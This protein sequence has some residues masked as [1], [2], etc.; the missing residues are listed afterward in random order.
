VRRFE[1]REV[2]PFH[3]SVDLN[4]LLRSIFQNLPSPDAGVRPNLCSAAEPV[5]A[6]CDSHVLTRAV[7]LLLAFTSRQARSNETVSAGTRRSASGVELWLAA[8]NDSAVSTA[9]NGVSTFTA[10]ELTDQ[11]ETGGSIGNNLSVF[12]ATKLVEALGGQVLFDDTPGHGARFHV[13][14]PEARGS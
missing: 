13:V 9:L 2:A 11:T 1:R 6:D 8:T 12:L 5:V 14:L 7:A 10:S 4:A 3:S